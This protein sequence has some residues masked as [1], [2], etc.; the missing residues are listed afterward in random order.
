[1]A[2]IIEQVTD[3]IRALLSKPFITSLDPFYPDINTWYHYQVVNQLDDSRSILIHAYD[4]DNLVGVAI[5]KK[6]THGK[7]RCVRVT[8]DLENTGLGIRLI[9]HT[10][11]LIEDRHPLITVSEELFHQ[12]SR[13]FH[14]YYNFKIE[15]VKKGL[16]R[17]NK[18]EYIYNHPFQ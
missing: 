2:I 10:L 16:Y 8:K 15:Q 18:L 14:H 12:Y 13:A 6:G 17:N 7:L 1:M 5:A 11:D 3:P 9:N 4:N